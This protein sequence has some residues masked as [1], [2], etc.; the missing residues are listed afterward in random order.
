[1]DDLEN[2]RTESE[3]EKLILDRIYSAEKKKKDFL[4]ESG[5]RG[6][7]SL[8]KSINILRQKWA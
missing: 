5:R 3:R 8:N 2:F 1:M 6:V 4:K 7:L